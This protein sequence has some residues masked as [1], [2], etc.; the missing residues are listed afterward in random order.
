MF[1]IVFLSLLVTTIVVG[2]VGLTMLADVAFAG[3]RLAR[4]ASP[5]S[6]KRAGGPAGGFD[7]AG[8]ALR[9]EQAVTRVVASL[10]MK[11]TVAGTCDAACR[12]REIQVTTP[13]VLAMVQELRERQTP[14]EI[15]AIRMQAERNLMAHDLTHHCPLLMSGGFCACEASRPVSCRT[16]CP[17]GAD[18]PAEARQLAETVGA[19][20]TDIFRDCLQASG[21]DNS[22]YEL[23]YAI[24]HVL[25]TPDAA[26][27]WARGEQILKGPAATINA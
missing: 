1:G 17:A 8:L 23:N 20:V 11:A 24:A 2:C 15:H 6:S 12:E 25:K 21:L 16:R 9:L 26:D 22:R 3:P 4:Q 10:G 19:G 7:G 14:A 13:E 18:S 27:R 5:A